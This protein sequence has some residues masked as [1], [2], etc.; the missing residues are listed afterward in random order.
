MDRREVV[1]VGRGVKTGPSTTS[2]PQKI[3]AEKPPRRHQYLLQCLLP[4]LK[5]K[6]KKTTPKNPNNQNT[7]QHTLHTPKKLQNDTK[8]QL[9]TAS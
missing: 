4:H 5:K 1:V 9:D 7:P 8:N 3:G 2:N 6:P